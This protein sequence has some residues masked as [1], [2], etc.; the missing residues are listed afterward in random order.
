MKKKNS[1]NTGLQTP[2]ELKPYAP[3]WFNQLLGFLSRFPTPKWVIFSAFSFLLFLI[4][5]G[6]NIKES[7]GNPFQFPPLVF[8]AFIQIAYVLSLIDFLDQR[9]ESAI[10]EYKPVLENPSK[11]FDGLKNRLITLPARSVNWITL[12]VIAFF[13]GLGVMMSQNQSR[14]AES[15]EYASYLDIFS[16]SP[17]GLY[18]IGVVALLWLINFIFIFHTFHQLITVDFIFTRCSKINIF[19]KKEFFAFSKVSAFTAIG[20]VFSS[21]LWIIFERSSVTLV[22]NIVFS[23]LAI[24]IFLL[25]LAGAHR[26]LKKQKDELR[27]KIS[28]E[29][30][31]VIDNIFASLQKSNYDEM[32]P[33][34]LALSTIGDTQ[35]EIEKTSTWPWESETTRQMLGALL[36]P[37]AIWLIQYFLNQLLSV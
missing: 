20:L 25:P 9:A 37:I 24:L 26:Q 23:L 35:K 2:K 36:L 27:R 34:D 5:A 17:V 4:A 6:I 7:P 32:K 15:A 31:K 12:I 28:S 13:A 8:L 29:K 19:Q 18:S 30:E 3:S 21:P 16:A 10:E 22:I 14:L 1:L 11:D 33:L